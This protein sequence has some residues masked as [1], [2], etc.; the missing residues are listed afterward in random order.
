MSQDGFTLHP[1]PGFE[2]YYAS[3]D[4]EIIGRWGRPLKQFYD[5]DG[6]KRV[7]LAVERGAEAKRAQRGVHVFV[8]LAFHGPK[9]TPRHEVR[10]LNGKRDH[11]DPNNVCWA[12]RKENSDDRII[13]G[14]VPNGERS[15][16]AKLTEKQVKEIRCLLKISAIDPSTIHY[17]DGVIAREYGVSSSTIR[18]I[19]IGRIWRHL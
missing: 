19:R 17:S 5:R 16:R 10:H 2:G 13:H 9:P 8:C 15:N 12:T 4:G 6:Y 11:N 3:T 1:I 7:S 14:T 18:L